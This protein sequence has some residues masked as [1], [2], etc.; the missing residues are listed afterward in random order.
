MKTATMLESSNNQLVELSSSNREIVDKIKFPSNYNVQ[1]IENGNLSMVPIST[2]TSIYLDGTDSNNIV[3]SLAP[4]NRGNMA[5]VIQGLIKG[6]EVRIN[7]TWVFDLEKFYEICEEDEDSILGLQKLMYINSPEVQSED[8]LMRCLM[9]LKEVDSLDSIFRAF[10]E[11]TRE[12]LSA[13]FSSSDENIVKVF[14]K[15]RRQ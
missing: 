7:D 8:N 14:N 9:I 13:I 5:N 10:D 3:M 6:E 2:G 11:M 15:M 4:I 12:Q 1:Q